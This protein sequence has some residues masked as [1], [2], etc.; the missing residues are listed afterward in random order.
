MMPDEP[1]R[2]PA[3]YLAKTYGDDMSYWQDHP[4]PSQL[5]ISEREAWHRDAWDREQMELLMLTRGEAGNDV[6][7]KVS[8]FGY[9]KRGTALE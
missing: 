1:I 6:P 2:T 3:E 4:H 5:P 7:G 8:T 9:D